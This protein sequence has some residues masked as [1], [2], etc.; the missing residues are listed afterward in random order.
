MEITSATAATPAIKPAASPAPAISS[1]F[2]TFL[3]MLTAQMQNQ[4]PLNPLNSSDFAVQLATFSGVEQQVQ[5]NALLSGLGTQ[6]TQMGMAQLSGWVG[7]DAR[8]T[9]PV[10]FHG[11]PIELAPTPAPGADKAQLVVSDASGREVQRLAAQ[12]DGKPVLWAG[13]DATGTP[14]PDG[15]YSFT[16]DSFAAGT[17]IDSAA[18]PAY[19][20]ITEAR[21]GPSGVTLVLSGGTTVA[22][23]NVSGLRQPG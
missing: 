2:T 3:K 16:L 8:V 10:G 6:M 21:T 23:G 17:N 18:V 14:L 5:T 19:V 7:M 1:D 20:P 13:T 22:A 12:L 11:A 4:D 9:V 15:A